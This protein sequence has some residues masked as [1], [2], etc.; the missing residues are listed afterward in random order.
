MNTGLSL[1]SMR[2]WFL[3]F[4]FQPNQAQVPF[5]HFFTCAKKRIYHV[6]PCGVSSITKSLPKLLLS[7]SIQYFLYFNINH[8]DCLIM[9]FLV[10]LVYCVKLM[11]Y[12]NLPNEI[13]NPTKHEKSKAIHISPIVQGC[14][15][16]C[17][18]RPKFYNVLILLYSI[19]SS[20]L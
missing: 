9:V 6:R 19:C 5:H 4:N 11:I 8:H 2:Y 17:W 1:Q 15:N 18:G 12:G 7:T 3:F 10:N 16:I 13:W 20:K 14:M